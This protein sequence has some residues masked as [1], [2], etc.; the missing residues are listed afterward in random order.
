MYPLTQGFS[1]SISLFVLVAALLMGAGTHTPDIQIGTFSESSAETPFEDGWMALS[2]GK[3]IAPTQY[4]LIDYDGVRVVRATSENSA[5]GLVKEADI[6]PEQY[7]VL[8]WRWNVENRLEQGNMF[9]K[10]GDD[11]AA[12][13]YV[14]FEYDAKRL[15]LGERI[16]YE[17]LRL[18]G[19][20]NIPL[21][22][23]NY[24]WA[25][26][27]PA[28]TVA[29][30]AYTDWVKMIAVR[31]SSDAIDTWHEEFQNVY[32]DYE[33]AFGEKPGRITGIAIMT[34]TD[35][36]GE[37]ATAYFGDISFARNPNPSRTLPANLLDQ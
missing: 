29:S 19:Y 33:R 18:L 23:L 35:N 28:G 10:K 8:Q 4:E 36:T 26:E 25:N 6:D 21:R 11:F 3:K 2:L 1:R 24:V 37:S 9:R 20:K 32:A 17:A 14:T 31:D 30:N 13:I 5:S 16:K 7:P 22:A 15:G 12:R 27:A 34:D